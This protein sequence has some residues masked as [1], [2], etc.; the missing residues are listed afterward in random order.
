MKS[1][2]ARTEPVDIEQI[3]PPDKVQKVVRQSIAGK[4]I[5]KVKSVLGQ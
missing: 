5:S 2:K 1:Y 4:V 3:I